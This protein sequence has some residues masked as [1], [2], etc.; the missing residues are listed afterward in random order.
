MSNNQAYLSS[1]YDD[2]KNLGGHI[3]EKDSAP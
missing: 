1:G 3:E 2:E